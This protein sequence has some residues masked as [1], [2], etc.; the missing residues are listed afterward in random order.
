MEAT[1]MMKGRKKGKIK[2]MRETWKCV[3]VAY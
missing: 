3:P 2:R 1:K